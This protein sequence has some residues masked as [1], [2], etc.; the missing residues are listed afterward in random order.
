MYDVIV[1]GGGHNGLTCAAYL[2]RAGQRVIVLEGQ[3]V[4]GGMTL[5]H[6][7][8]PEA[9]GFLMSSC[10]VD[11]I[12]IHIP[13]SI[14]G[15]LGLARYGL[16]S[17]NVDPY[18]S[19]LSPDGGAI[20][21]WRDLDRTAAEIAKFSRRDAD[22]YHR[23]A[24]A[25]CDLWYAAMPY[26]QGHPRRLDPQMLLEIAWRVAKTRK[27]L[28]TA[29][30]IMLQSPAEALEEWFESDEL[31]T[32]LA[33]WAAAGMTD[34]DAP[35][36]GGVM[37]MFVLTHRW[38]CT[39]PLGGMGSL[40]QALAA[41]VEAHGGE[42]RTSAPVREIIIRDGRASGVVLDTGEEIHG[43][44]VVGALDPT[45]LLTKLM[46]P[47][48]LPSQVQHELRGMS[49]LRNNMS[50]FKG[51][52]ALSG[53]PHFPRHGRDEE[54]LRGG[55]IMLSPDL[56][57]VRRSL[58]ATDRGEL[59]D[60]IPIW[61]AMP[62]MLDRSLVPPGST[63]ESLYVYVPAVPYDLANGLDWPSEKEKYLDRCMTIIDGYAPGVKDKIIGMAA[64]KSPVDLEK[65]AHKGH[66]LHVDMTLSQLG[67]WRPTPS[68]SG[69]RTP[70]AGLWHTASG[71]HPAPAV[72]GWSG[73]TTARTILRAAKKTKRP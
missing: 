29:L 16:Q 5:T 20:A 64:S 42:V 18:C 56:D 13:R 33:L 30:R 44:H 21:F 49:V 10:A 57:Y 45:T 24:T 72:N 59:S 73:R 46:D 68:L 41:C 14:I 37:S 60:E 35:G 15:E 51:D 58:T 63:G 3:P 31:K 65:F 36:S 52:V 61:F 50:L 7:P 70:I 47:A 28:T 53:R 67:P 32:A 55:Y 4:I 54:F 9:P 71:A 2:A 17:V 66:I 48:Q 23:F 40:S 43:T 34:L 1:A 69:Y 25:L 39:R 38:G 22:R 11:M 62:T 19:W 27:N 6:E 8:V 12:L 26:V